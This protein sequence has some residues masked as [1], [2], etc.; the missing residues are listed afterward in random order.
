[1]MK[2]QKT[3]TLPWDLIIGKLSNQLSEQEAMTFSEWLGQEKNKEIFAE[4]SRLWE[5]VQAHSRHYEP[6]KSY[7]WK[8]LSEKLA[9][10]ETFVRRKSIVRSIYRYL[11]IAS[12][13]LLLLGISFYAG[14]VYNDKGMGKGDAYAHTYKNIGGKSKLTLP[15]GTLVWL[16]AESE[17]AYDTDFGE[18]ERNV[19][20]KGEAYFE[21]VSRKEKPFT[22]HSG[23]VEVN[24]YGTKFNVEAFPEEE[25]IAVSLLEGSVALSAGTLEQTLVPGETGTY[26]KA[27][28]TLFVCKDDVAFAASWA[29]DRL[30]FTNQSLGEITRFLSKWYQVDIYV[31]PE[32]TRQH[33]YTFTL[34]HEP[35][36]EI[37]R[38]M[39]RIHP[40]TYRF[41]SYNNLYISPKQ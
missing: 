31:A 39:S 29:Q 25:E 22:V 8:Q 4:I 23:A 5:S 13:L 3:H 32:L 7:Y 17:L 35:L 20:L 9:L 12:C 41:D 18:S 11:A 38:L 40:F 26:H 37:V 10:D 27:N 34:Q 19:H 24:V 36:E 16:H 6:D 33:A 15:D 21:V 1:M 30:V 28:Q 2:K 14:K